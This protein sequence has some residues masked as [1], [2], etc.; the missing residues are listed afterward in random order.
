[1]FSKLKKNRKLIELSITSVITIV[2][3]VIGWHLAST[4]VQSQIK[5]NERI[6]MVNEIINNRPDIN[7]NMGPYKTGNKII[8]CMGTH[9][10]LKG[11][12][13]PYIENSSNKVA[14]NVLIE[15]K[16]HNIFDKYE[17]FDVN[18]IQLSSIEPGQKIFIGNYPTSS[19]SDITIHY[20][21]PLQEET[22]EAVEFDKNSNSFNSQS[23]AFYDNPEL[24]EYL[25]K[26]N[27]NNAQV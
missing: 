16:A 1:M 18:Y 5:N 12:N 10:E 9:S 4:N 14:K 24:V 13:I 27:N 17:N 3:A 6:Q 20:E 2:I 8:F 26:Y 19:L 23:T 21:S 7:I 15:V 11:N 22:I 25:K